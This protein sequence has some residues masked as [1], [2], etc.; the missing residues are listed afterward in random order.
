MCSSDLVVIFTLPGLQ[1]IATNSRGTWAFDFAPDAK[2]VLL[3]TSSNIVAWDPA[4]HLERPL[5][6]TYSEEL[7]FSPG[8]TD[9]AIGSWDNMV[10]L[11]NL[12]SPAT[13]ILLNGHQGGVVALDFSPDGK[14]LASAA[15]DKTIRLWNLRT[16][17]QVACLRR[18]ETAYWLR[19]TPD[20]RGLMAG[21]TSQA[22]LLDAR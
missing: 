2:T 11:V 19:F 8:G 4:T 15:E 7:A 20:G 18:Q 17:R 6:D 1:P 22:E 13:P 12:S 14:T 10:R 16:Q 21:S 5:I 9:M 3:A